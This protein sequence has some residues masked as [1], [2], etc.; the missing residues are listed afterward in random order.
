MP[1]SSADRKI[2]DLEFGELIRELQIELVD[3]GKERT[4]SVRCGLDCLKGDDAVRY[5]AIHDAAR[6]LVSQVDLDAVFT[7]VQQTQAAI[8]AMRMPG[9]VK[10][11]T[12]TLQSTNSVDR[13][14]LWIALTPQVFEIELL[15][16]AYEKYRGRPATD[17]AE[18]VQ[19]IGHAVMLV[20]GSA[21]N[22]KITHPEDLMIA[23]AILKRQSKD[24]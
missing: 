24:A 9:S 15:Q 18:L 2:F 3:G 6:P 16:A 20:P 12:E 17:D 11:E 7:A 19:R 10:R 1:V 8:L 5:V 14:D 21:E 13:S 22:I 23:E 4:D